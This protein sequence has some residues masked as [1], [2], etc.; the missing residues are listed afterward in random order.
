MTVQEIQKK[1]RKIQDDQESIYEKLDRLQQKFESGFLQKSIYD[2]V[3]ESYME[4]VDELEYQKDYVVYEH[5]VEIVYQVIST[6]SNVN[7]IQDRLLDEYNQDI[8]YKHTITEVNEQGVVLPTQTK[9]SSRKATK[10]EVEAHKD[11]ICWWL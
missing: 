5:K 1:N 11:S 6:S 3:Y 2:Y 10:E 4:K 9:I 7:Q 8:L